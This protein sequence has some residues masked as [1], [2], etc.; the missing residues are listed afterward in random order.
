MSFGTF[1]LLKYAVFAS[2][3]IFV[4]YW[5]RKHCRILKRRSDAHKL[6]GTLRSNDTMP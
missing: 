1:E 6:V 2:L 3:I 5:H 4:S